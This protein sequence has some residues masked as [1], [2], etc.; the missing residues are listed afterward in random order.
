[1]RL[2]QALD[3]QQITELRKTH[4]VG[5]HFFF[6][7]H[8]FVKSG[9]YITCLRAPLDT[10]ISSILFVSKSTVDRLSNSETAEFVKNL[11][12]SGVF[13]LFSFLFSNPFGRSRFFTALQA[14]S[15][16]TL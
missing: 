3:S 9:V 12:A 15:I 10:A 11:F 5:G 14:V 16:E 13:S 1:L 8:R 6:G 2:V 7:F 4:V